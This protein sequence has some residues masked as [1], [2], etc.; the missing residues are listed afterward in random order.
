MEHSSYPAHP[1]PS[2]FIWR[3]LQSFMGLWLVLFL[4]EHLFTNSQAALFFGDDGNGFVRAVNALKNLPYL[5][6][7]EV[8]LIG[9]P[10]LVHGGWGI[11]YLFTS[12]SNSWG[13]DGT[14]PYLPEYPR[15]HA[16]TWQRITSWI[17][18]IGIIAHVVDMRFI[19]YP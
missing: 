1:L 7:I 19:H 5:S 13:N 3:R 9:V 8:T 15:N 12:K 18:L 6:V 10:F 2:A 17:L 14:R 4:I 11:Y 16:Y